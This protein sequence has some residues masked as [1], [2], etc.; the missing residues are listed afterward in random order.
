VPYGFQGALNPE[1]TKGVK[2]HYL[3]FETFAQLH[4]PAK[5][6]YLPPKKE[7]GIAPESRTHWAEFKDVAEPIKNAL[8][9]KRSVLC[10]QKEGTDYQQF[11]IVWW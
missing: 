7:W 9:A 8:T 11:F 1:F 4:N 6:Y 3:N 2:G 5:R 10:W